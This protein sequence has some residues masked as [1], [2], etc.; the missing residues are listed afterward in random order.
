MTRRSHTTEGKRGARHDGRLILVIGGASSGKSEAALNLAAKGLA[1]GATRAF[2]ATGQARDEEMTVKIQRHRASRGAGWETSE[3]PTD[4][5]A[6]FQKHGRFYRAIVVDCLTL[7]LSNLRE[8]GIRDARILSLLTEL[9]QAMR[10]SLARVVVV[11]NELGLGLVPMDVAA[12]RFR[13]L[14]GQ[15]NQQVAAEADEVHFVV[16]GRPFRIK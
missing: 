3:V 2:V 5:L 15:V 9:L 11:S 13:D 12:R 6:W 10:S 7:W 14:A 8:R 4:L 16:A 1:R